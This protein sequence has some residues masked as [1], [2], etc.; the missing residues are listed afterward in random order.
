V[1]PSRGA[2]DDGSGVIT[3]SL[4]GAQAHRMWTDIVG[5]ALPFVHIA[6]A[7][8]DSEKGLSGYALFGSPTPGVARRGDYAA[9]V[10]DWGRIWFAAEWIP[11]KC[12]T[13]TNVVCRTVNANWVRLRRSLA[14]N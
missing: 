13:I 1:V 4:S 14:S 5:W 7:R 9:A 2:N 10:V 12:S 11:K 3:F 6:G 8:M